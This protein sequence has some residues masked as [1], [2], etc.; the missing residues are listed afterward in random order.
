MIFLL[1]FGSI[2]DYLKSF[3][4]DI[5]SRLFLCCC[6]F[7][8]PYICKPCFQ[9]LVLGPC[10]FSCL[11]LHTLIFFQLK[12]FTWLLI[13]FFTFV[14]NFL[15]SSQP[16]IFPWFLFKYI[17]RRTMTFMLVDNHKKFFFSFSIALTRIL[18]YMVN[19]AFFVLSFSLHLS[20]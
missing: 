5:S 19:I 15:L 18:L 6:C 16:F 17:V 9:I 1:F 8:Q 4:Y 2:F 10:P 7:L 3:A 11:I 20:V 13:L 14:F 12:I